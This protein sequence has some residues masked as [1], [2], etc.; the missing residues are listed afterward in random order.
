MR[1]IT[2]EALAELKPNAMVRMVSQG[3]RELAEADDPAVVVR[4]GRGLEAIESAMR[5]TG[6]FKP[7][8][9]R[10]AN[11][12]KFRARWK[13]GKLLAQIERGK[14]GRKGK[15]NVSV[16]QTYFRA[17]LK[18]LA[19]DKSVALDAQR[20]GAMPEPRLLKVFEP[21]RGTSDYLTYRELIIH[22]RPFWHQEKRVMNHQRI[23][24]Q[25]A[26]IRTPDTLGPFALVYWDPPW[27][28][29]AH[30]PEMTHRMPDD[31]YPVMTDEEIIHT[32]FGGQHVVTMFHNDCSMFMWCTSSNI[33]RALAVME[34]MGFEYKAQAIWDKG[35][36]GTGYIFRNQH[37]VLL[38]GSIGN[39]PKPVELFSSVFRG[40]KFKRGEHSA[41][42][43]AVRKIIEKM[44]PHYTTEN[45]VEI[46]ARGDVKGWTVLGH[47]A[48]N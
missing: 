38:Y 36:I 9:V 3:L 43:D 24:R 21:Y 11:E 30:T 13:L 29:E 33:Q 20:I 2:S 16:S 15:K 14:A 25:S 46:F 40:P 23:V 8:Q 17:L 5:T 28:F 7:E 12:G 48:A 22:A 44:Y 1:L 4:I 26:K 18:E 31:H 19:L 27:K 45:R 39:P 10:E 41:K 34:R 42:P 6:L 37:E 32:Q 47:E 35:K